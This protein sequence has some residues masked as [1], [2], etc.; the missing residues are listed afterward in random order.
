[1]L[2][3]GLP[4]SGSPNSGSDKGNIPSTA[5]PSATGT[6]A[7]TSYS[8]QLGDRYIDCHILVQAK[9]TL[10]LSPAALNPALQDVPP[11]NLAATRKRRGT[12]FLRI[13]A[14][15]TLAPAYPT[16]HGLQP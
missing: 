10:S 12:W 5:H 8:G 6:P 14:A 7:S 15:P 13:V 2:V 16:A 4:S 9:L 1:M 3:G 11:P